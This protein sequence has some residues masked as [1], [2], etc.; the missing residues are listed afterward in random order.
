MV[1]PDQDRYGLGDH[2]HP[3]GE[4]GR[5]QAQ[6]KEG[7]RHRYRAGDQHRQNHGYIWRYAE[8]GEVDRRVCADADE[9]LLA[10]RQ[11][12][13][14]AGERIPHHGE[15]DQDQQV[16]QVLHVVGV[17]HERHE[18]EGDREHADAD[19]EVP[20]QRRPALDLQT[21]AHSEL[22][23]HCRLARPSATTPRS[24]GRETRPPPYRT[25]STARN[26]TWPASASYWGWICAPSV[27]ATPR[28]IPP[29]SVP[30]S[31]PIPPITTASKAKISWIGPLKGSNTDRIARK[32][33]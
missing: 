23:A 5:A 30:Q 33:P 11:E 9:S 3:D 25:M 21:R 19:G 18:R 10:H 31:E 15:D 13:T 8:L 2:P 7:D 28:A 6:R 22:L 27:C 26:N 14:I 12:A 1:E 17:Q 24:L 29:T 32:S 4:L 16:R 20:R